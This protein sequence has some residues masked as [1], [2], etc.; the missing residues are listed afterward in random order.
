MS[1]VAVV[2]AEKPPLIVLNVSIFVLTA[3][4]TVAAFTQRPVV[5]AYA[6][7]SILAGVPVYYLWQVVK[8][9]KPTPGA[10]L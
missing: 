1:N 6:L 5:S 10:D 4:V 7:L 9:Q 8:G 3:L 2:Q